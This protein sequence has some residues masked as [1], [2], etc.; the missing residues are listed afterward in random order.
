M[1]QGGLKLGILGSAGG[2]FGDDGVISGLGGVEGVDGSEN[3]GDLGSGLGEVGG[4]CVGG[5]LRSF[6]MYLGSFGLG[7]GGLRALCGGL[8]LGGGLFGGAVGG[9]LHAVGGLLCAFRGC[10]CALCG[11]LCLG[12]GLF[13]GEVGSLLHAVS[14][15][16]RALG[17]SLCLGG[18]AVGGI[19][20]RLMGGLDGLCDVETEGF[21]EVGDEI[22][23]GL[24]DLLRVAADLE[25]LL[26]GEVATLLDVEVVGREASQ[27]VDDHCG[28]G[29]WG[30]GFGEDVLLDDAVAVAV[31]E[32][33]VGDP[34]LADHMDGVG[35]AGAHVDALE[36]DGHEDDG[37]VGVAPL[38]TGEEGDSVERGDVILEGATAV[39]GELETSA[40]EFGVGE[41]DGVMEVLPGGEVVRSW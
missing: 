13:G 40:Y 5:L 32:R 22:V 6:G 33:G 18:S 7:L 10:L 12:G 25:P 31:G 37:V 24:H 34:E 35:A 27:G 8:C 11:G 23:D 4:G 20:H 2:S 28:V 14:G 19:H 38:T 3:L 29:R 16:L 15:L 36:V 1:T 30:V 39:V 41:L 17:R 26:E 21:A 9:L